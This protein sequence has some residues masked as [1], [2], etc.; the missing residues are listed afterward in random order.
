M[1]KKKAN[2]RT[3][4]LAQRLADPAKRSKLP[5]SKLT[6]VQQKQRRANQARA[7]V[8]A[9]PLYNPAA[10]LTGQTLKQVVDSSVDMQFAPRERQAQQNL[11]NVTTQGGALANR[12]RDVYQDIGERDTLSL[13]RS[14]AIGAVLDNALQARAKEASAE[15]DKSGTVLAEQRAA[16]PGAE[17]VF[18]S[19]ADELGALRARETANQS[20]AAAAASTQSGNWQQLLNAMAQARQMQGGE[21]QT[22][23]GNRLLNQQN[24]GRAALG[25]IASEKGALRATRTLDLRDQ[26][27][28]NALAQNQLEIKND[29]IDATLTG[30][31]SRERV[32]KDNRTAAQKRADL[33]AATTRRGQD[34]TRKN[35][36][37]RL[38]THDKNGKPL[39][40]EKERKRLEAV[41]GKSAKAWQN[42][43]TTL[44]KIQSGLRIPVT[45]FD[46]ASGKQKDTGK[47]RPATTAETKAQLLAEGTPT[48]AIEAA[49]SIRHK[50][51][52]D[53]KTIQLI[54][55]L[56]P[57]V[58]IPSQYRKPPRRQLGGSRTG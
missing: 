15:F 19:S 1:A 53:D 45:T 9:D 36:L 18:E 5:M 57:E 54:R 56:A 37:D 31:K 52:V 2:V 4:T 27:F 10:P 13:D 12:A 35:A 48:W 30:I 23:L 55:R 43:D 41:R 22:E 17:A 50:G 7:K 32:A 24:E 38:R 28:T 44:A 6:P 51:Y 11:L 42:V 49:V 40:P 39:D 46:P 21:V 25:D 3:Y 20:G 29:Q 16:V 34:L 47:V 26:A 33:Q 14:K 8:N 58:R